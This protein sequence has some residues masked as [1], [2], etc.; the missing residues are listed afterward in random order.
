MNKI[1]KTLKTNKLIYSYYK[2]LKK[3]K[4]SI[5][6][7]RISNTAILE[8]SSLIE[9]GQNIDI[10]EYVII[11]THTNKVII[12]DNSQLN[13]FTVIY[14]GSGVEIGRN[15]MIAPHVMIAG[16][17][18]NYKDL[19]KPMRFAGSNSKGKIII[20]DDVWIG[21]NCVITDGVT[22]GKGAIV[23]A[24]SVV[25]QNVKEFDVVG[26]IPTNFFFNRLEK[27]SNKQ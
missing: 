21:A 8:K 18:H 5:A 23:A 12:G 27:Y 6:K 14:G 17:N 22:I 20:E 4:M 26:G 19:S 25:T 15:V 7:P 3:Y 13:P 10:W 1:K 16:G 24:G 11:K 9:L 2:K